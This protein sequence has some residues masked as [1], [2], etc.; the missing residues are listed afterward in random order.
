MPLC[1][2]LFL[3]SSRPLNFIFS[4][5]CGLDNSQNGTL[6][7][8]FKTL[9]PVNISQVFVLWVFVQSIAAKECRCLSLLAPAVWFR[10]VFVLISQF[11]Q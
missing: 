8:P 9:S 1:L 4:R 2:I 11:G 10:N 6:V 3:N 5:I 7:E